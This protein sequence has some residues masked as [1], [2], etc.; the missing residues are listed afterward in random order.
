MDKLKERSQLGDFCIQFGLPDT[1]ANSKK[2]KHR[3]S[4]Y[5]N[6]DKPYKKKRS[7][8][9]SK[10][11][12]DTRKIFCKSNR[13][14]KNRFKRDLTKIKCYR[15]GNF[16]HIAPNCKFEKLKSLEL[17][18]EVHDKVYSFL[19]TSGSEPDYD[20]DS[21]SDEEV[22]LLDISYSNQHDKINVCNSCHEL[23]KEVT[24]NDLQEKIIHLVANNNANSSSSKNSEKQK[25]H[26][27]FEYVAP[28]SLS[29]INNRL[30][31][32]TTPTRDSSFDD[33]KNEI[34]NLKNEIKSLKQ[35]QMIC[36]HRLNQ[37]ENVNN[38]G[39]NIVEE[40]TLAKPFNLDP[41]Q[42]I[43][44]INAIYPFTSINAESFTATYEDR[45]ISYTFITDPISHMCK[46]ICGT[47][48][49]WFLNWWSYHDSTIKILPD[50]FHKLYKEW[51]KVSP[52][53][54][55]LYNTDHICY[56]EKID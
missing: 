39:K 46:D 4:R 55:E 51:V 50:S 33:L 45:D 15:C 11:E 14:T 36:D 8:Y 38:K 41:R 27:E 17:D 53:L 48:S 23:S 47:N 25:N 1:S 52:D 35:N 31:K 20:S 6:P 2:K 26:F 10:E 49:N 19:Y 5:S 32:Q 54:D 24:D 29:K 7:R 44:F 37:I 43:P 56:L 16:S 3:D 28:Y 12:R 22:D 34:E 40:N 42:V 13:F 30:N 21:G 9:R 18:E